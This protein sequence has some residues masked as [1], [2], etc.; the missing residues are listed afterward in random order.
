MSKITR[1]IFFTPSP[2][3]EY[4]EI[5]NLGERYWDMGTCVAILKNSNDGSFF[6]E[7]DS[8]KVFTVNDVKRILVSNER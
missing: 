4:E 1:I 7:F 8:N 2:S 3:G 5:I 6:A